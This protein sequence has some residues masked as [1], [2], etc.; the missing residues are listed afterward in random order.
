MYKAGS[1]FK[2]ELSHS[3]LL[4]EVGGFS[5]QWFEEKKKP[6]FVMFFYIVGPD[7]TESACFWSVPGVEKGCH[8]Y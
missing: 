6:F 2:D 3:A 4:S 7:M 5:Q 1:E 8:F